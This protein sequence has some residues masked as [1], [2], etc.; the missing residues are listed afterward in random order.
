M[1]LEYDWTYGVFRPR[2]GHTFI[3]FRGWRS[4]STLE[5]AKEIIGY[6]GLSLG[7]KTDS[8]TWEIIEQKR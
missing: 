5:E 1:F 8:R 7:K 6:A 3:D 4:F 2:F